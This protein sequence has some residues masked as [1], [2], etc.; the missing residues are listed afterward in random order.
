MII[1]CD[2]YELITIHQHSMYRL[3]G[4]D[5]LDNKSIVRTLVG[6]HVTMFHK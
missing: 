3:A 5:T 2:Q 6:S 4:L 1:I